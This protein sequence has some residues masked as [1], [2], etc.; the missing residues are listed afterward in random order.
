MLQFE[1]IGELDNTLIVVTSDNGM[2]FPRAKAT[3]YEAG[4][5]VPLAVQWPARIPQIR[6]LL[7]VHCQSSPT[8]ALAGFDLGVPAVAKVA[9]TFG[10]FSLQPKLF[11]SFATPNF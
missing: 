4:T 2:P 7:V 9:K 10:E 11:A 6:F 3:L 1:A 8:S 5:R